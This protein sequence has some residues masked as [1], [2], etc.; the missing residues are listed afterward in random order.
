MTT[1]KPASQSQIDLLTRLLSEREV[2]AESRRWI[3]E[4]LAHNA[5]TGGRGGTASRSIE[6]LF[7]C[8][9]AVDTVSAAEATPGYYVRGG[10]AFKVQANKAGTHTYA[11][12]WSGSSWDYA[13]GVGRNLAG[14]VP[15]TA[16]QAASIGL[17][18][19]RCIECCRTLGGTTV[20]AKAAAL[21]GYGEIC[22]SRN[23]W[24]FP[25]GAAAQR[26]FV[27]ERATSD[28]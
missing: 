7:N 10:D 2:P 6:H 23:G 3:N 17:A 4:A 18:A 24:A 15:M 26:A 20:T 8:P 14:L 22:A 27:A 12:V 9:K 11:L 21:I 13:P 25:K 1:T 5:L 28:H 19:G 16:E